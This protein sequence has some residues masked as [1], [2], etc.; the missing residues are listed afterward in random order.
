MKSV[1]LY[2][3]LVILIQ[4][5]QTYFRF[6]ID[7]ERNNLKLKL[8]YRFHKLNCC[9]YLLWTSILILWPASNLK[10][11]CKISNYIF[12]TIHLF[13][14]SHS[15]LLD[16]CIKIILLKEVQTFDRFYISLLF[17]EVIVIKTKLEKTWSSCCFDSW[18]SRICNK[19]LTT[20]LVNV[21]TWK[22]F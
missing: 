3:M 7:V 1:L 4:Y 20:L 11:K 16:I 19:K 14:L 21:K 2:I 10:V 12:A 8:R 22:K 15:P 5:V 18:I 13:N 9:N 6:F 17:N